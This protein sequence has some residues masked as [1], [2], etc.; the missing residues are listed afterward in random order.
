MV[1]KQKKVE[2]KRQPTRRQ[3]SKWRRQ[4]Q[5]QRIIIAVGTLFLVC[6]AVYVGYGYYNEQV[7][8]FSQPVIRVN[9]A[10]FDMNY[11]V[12]LLDFLSRGQEP[13][14]LSAMTAITT[15]FL[16]QGELIRERAGE[17]GVSVTEAEIDDGLASLQLPDEK[18]YRDFV[19]AKLLADKLMRDHFDTKV[20][21]VCEQVKV[22]AMLLES[23]KAAA[24]I[25]DK[26]EAGDDF[27]TLAEKASRE[28]ITE[29]KK[30]D[31]GWLPKGFTGF[32]LPE[33]ADSQL[34]DIAFSLE[35]GMVSEP[36]YD[37]SVIKDIGYWILK[38][39]EK[40]A[41]K[42]SRISGILVGSLEEA[43]EIRA[44][45]EAGE[46][47]G[48]L[49]KQ[50][51]QHVSG[52]EGGELGWTRGGLLNRTIVA[53]AEQLEPDE[54]SKPVVDESVRT[55]GG[56]WLV[57]VVDRDANR[58]LDDETRET[59]KA[60]LFAEWVNELRGESLIEDYLTEEQKVWAVERVLRI[61]GKKAW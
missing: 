28:P 1:R 2:S 6:I 5:I 29:E 31:L 61:R 48:A 12:K 35:P 46:E 11:Y 38:V 9:D 3:L 47:F 16:V 53:F 13:A 40:D 23:R 54:L 10:V 43:E 50:Y 37:G 51:S 17:L 32:L 42:G 55:R 21:T 49:A 22:Q 39:T 36:T 44:K 52:E 60:R 57:K 8:P 58:Q 14:N 19:A 7:K 33:L 45:L 30:G 59:L 18:V 34:E 4:R 20:P 26:L 56:Y 15:D 25:R 41:G 24:E 27:A